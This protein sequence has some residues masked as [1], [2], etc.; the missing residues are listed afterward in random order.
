MTI[1]SICTA[2][3]P[4]LMYSD[5]NGYGNFLPAIRWFQAL[6][7][8]GGRCCCSSASML[9]WVRGVDDGC[10]VRLAVARARFS[11]PMKAVTV[12]AVVAMAA[13]A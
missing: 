10:E 11:A 5:M 7:G 2:K 4:G 13:L 3:T 9:L 6:L 8:I 1:A 12:V